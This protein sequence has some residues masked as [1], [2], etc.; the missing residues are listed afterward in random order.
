VTALLAGYM[1]G[2]AGDVSAFCTVWT[3]D[4]Y[5]MFIR[6]DPLDFHYVRME[7]WCTVV[8]V[9]ASIR[10]A[11][12]VMQFKSIMNYVQAF[13]SFFIAP[14]FGTVLLGMLWRRITP[15]GGFWELLSGTFSSLGTSALV[16]A[17]PSK[18]AIIAFSSQAKNMAE[19]MYRILWP[20]LICMICTVGV[21]VFTKPKAREQLTGLIYSCTDLPSEGHLPLRK[22]P[23]FLAGLSGATFLLLQWIFW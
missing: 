12:L 17:D 1:S 16:R 15:T 2:V 22:R 14:L 20:G 7:R 10:T 21:S 3:Y 23:I 11:Y 5:R 19:N 6:K 4:L 13:F 18:L 8:G 9:L